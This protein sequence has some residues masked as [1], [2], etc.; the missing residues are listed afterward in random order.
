MAHGLLLV[1]EHFRKSSPVAVVGDKKRVVAKSK[2]TLFSGHYFSVNLSAH[3]VV[4]LA[5]NPGEHTNEIGR[6]F[7]TRKYFQ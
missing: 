3:G 1:R 7:T 2:I 6:Q 4:H 5:P